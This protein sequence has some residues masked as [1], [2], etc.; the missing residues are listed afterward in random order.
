MFLCVCVSVDE[1]EEEKTEDN[2]TLLLTVEALK[3]QLEEQTR[4]CK[5][6]VTNPHI[7]RE[8]MYT[9]VINYGTLQQVYYIK[10]F[11]WILFGMGD[12]IISH[13]SVGIMSLNLTF[14]TSPYVHF[15]IQLA[16]SKKDNVSEK[17]ICTTLLC[18]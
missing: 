13:L 4:L 17:I 2:E 7:A 11:F 6:Q 10:G 1:D 18:V 9:Y 5:E 12:N 14:F 15:F 3:A 16:F 8:S